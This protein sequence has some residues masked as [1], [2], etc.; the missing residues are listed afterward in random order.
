MVRRA[1]LS[2]ALWVSV[3]C[4]ACDDS[5]DPGLSL[6]DAEEQ[7]S[8]RDAAVV[9]PGAGGVGGDIDDPEPGEGGAGGEAAGGAG[10]GGE[11]DVGVV[12]G[13]G[14]GGG[15]T[16]GATRACPSGCGVQT[17][18]VGAWGECAEDLERCDNADNDCDGL[19]DETFA[20]LGVG[21]Q[22]DQG[23]CQ[24]QGIQVCNAQGNGVECQA[25]P[26][27][28]EPEAC[29]GLDND[30]DDE[31]DEDFPGQ[32]C[33]TEDVHCPPGNVCSAGTCEG[34][35]GPVGPGPGGGGGAGCANAVDMPAFGRYAGDNSAGGAELFASCGGILGPEV[36]YSFSVNQTQRVRLD[37][38]G[39]LADT[40][41]YASSVCGDLFSELACDDDGGGDLSSVIEFEAQA[42]TRY[43]VV[44]DTSLFPGPFV[45]NFGPGG[46]A[47]PPV[48]CFDDF[49]C[50]LDEICDAG[51]CVPDGPVNPPAGAV[52]D[53]PT[54]MAA[55]GEYRGSTAG[56]PNT[57]N[58]HG[59]A[60]ATGGEIAF[61]FQL[62]EAAPIV[63]DTDASDFDTIVSIRSDCADGASEVACNDDGVGLQSRIEF[64][65]QAGVRYFVLVDGYAG[66]SGNVVVRF[67]GPP[68]LDACMAAAD[69]AGGQQCLASLCVPAT[70]AAC[71]AALPAVGAGPFVGTTVGGGN[72]HDP[73]CLASNS[74]EAIYAFVSPVNGTF[75]ASTAGSAFDTGLYVLEGCAEEVACN[76]DSVG[77]TSAV[78][79]DAVAGQV[80]Y[81]VVDGYNNASGAYQLTIQPE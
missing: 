40:L 79:F 55:W 63:I 39:S 64:N 4:W 50:G 47:P 2:L 16:D 22:V 17:C 77:L 6:P 25:P 75:R 34:D 1:P 31:V 66:D 26:A 67:E 19:V 29:D 13:A 72:L 20:A 14:G 18:V 60:R 12:G 46:A 80:Y 37:T 3:G 56:R 57:I 9:G 54:E 73:S 52:C 5:A 42:G 65:A 59:C 78:S 61:T 58:E 35:G 71:A 53:A 81:L 74:P 49:D 30:C 21:C 11:P 69:C 43:Y 7:R 44:V 76:D 8:V 36:V 23:A 10:G 27:E 51:A 45:L 15:C 41:L 70:P 32:F 68:Q 28:P 33:C 62:D 48:D 24:V 38:A